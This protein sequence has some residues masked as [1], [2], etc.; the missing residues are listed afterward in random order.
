MLTVLMKNDRT[1]LWC[2]LDGLAGSM[3]VRDDGGP[4]L[5][6][7]TSRSTAAS[8]HPVAACALPCSDG[9]VRCAASAA[10]RASWGS[11][12]GWPGEAGRSRQRG[13]ALERRQVCCLTCG[14]GRRRVAGHGRCTPPDRADLL[15]SPGCPLATGAADSRAG[16]RARIARR[17]RPRLP[18]AGSWERAR[19]QPPGF[20]SGEAQ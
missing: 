14:G 1:D 2:Q 18:V 17:K 7:S 16:F 11:R 6:R 12:P 15:A 20:A 3:R 5:P 8:G 4:L 13:H 19:R 10:S 9:S